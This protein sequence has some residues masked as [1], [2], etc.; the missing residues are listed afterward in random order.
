[1]VGYAQTDLI[2]PALAAGNWADLAEA[3]AAARV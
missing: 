2:I 1:L 3:N